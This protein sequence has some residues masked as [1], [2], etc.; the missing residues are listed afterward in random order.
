LLTL[1]FLSVTYSIDEPRH[2]MRHASGVFDRL[3]PESMNGCAGEYGTEDRPYG[4]NDDDAENRPSG[5]TEPA[6]GEDT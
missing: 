1:L 2:A 5:N 3:V 6:L 4:V